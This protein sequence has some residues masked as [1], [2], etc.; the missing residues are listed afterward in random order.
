MRWECG[1]ELEKYIGEWKRKEEQ[2]DEGLG[3]E[4]SIK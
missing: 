2:S 4:E 1:C 3:N